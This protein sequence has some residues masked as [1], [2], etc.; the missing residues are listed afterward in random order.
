MAIF[1]SKS[2]REVRTTP[3]HGTHPHLSVLHLWRSDAPLTTRIREIIRHPSSLKLI[4][5]SAVSIISTVVSQVILLLAF[6]VFRVMS[7]VPANILASAI[8]TIPSYVL[9]RRWVW[10]KDG[11]SSVWREIVP[12]WILS[13]IGLGVSSLAVWGAG[14]LSRQHNLSH[15]ETTIM[16]NAANLLSFGVLW[17]GKFIVYNKLFHISPV[18]FDEVHGVQSN[19][20]N[21]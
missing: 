9:N 17:L 21:V 5:Y 18:E 10:G 11:K 15:V 14:S 6:G 1:D 16:V 7:E 12:F 20:T 2:G 13:F 4:K 3:P 19:R 8:A